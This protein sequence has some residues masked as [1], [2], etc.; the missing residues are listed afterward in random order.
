MSNPTE[1]SL[2]EAWRRGWPFPGVIYPYALLVASAASATSSQWGSVSVNLTICAVAAVWM[3]IP[4]HP[5]PRRHVWAMTLFMAG[6]IAITAILVIRDPWFGFFVVAGYGYSIRLM[7]WPWTFPFIAA[8]AILAASAQTWSVDKG[9]PA[10]LVAYLAVIA[11]NMIS[12]CGIVWFFHGIE[13]AHDQR[14]RALDELSETNRRLQA[15]L[16]ENEGLHKQLLVQAREAGTLDERQRM[17]REIHDT[18]AQGLTGIITQLQ[19]AEHAAGQPAEWREHFAAA[20]GLARE[21]LSEARRSVDALRPE[22]LETGRLSDALSDAARRWSDLH[23]LEAKVVT[24]G[25]T[26]PMPSEAEIA[27]LRTAQEALANVARHAQATRVG[28]TLSYMEHEV[29]LDVRDDGK[30][31]AGGTAGGFGLIAMRQRIEGLAGTL[32]IESE[33]GLGTG[34]S[35]CIPAAPAEVPR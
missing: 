12:V 13:R 30:G 20:I 33:P 23:G 31:F 16:T 6:F 26:R 32:H 17:A 19:A 29:A 9:T 10:G 25:T 18:L 8:L 5:V 24:T 14:K 3:L 1:R 27:L 28:V 22:P 4:L 34:I 7:P 21:S 35:A 11:V 15:A 2:L